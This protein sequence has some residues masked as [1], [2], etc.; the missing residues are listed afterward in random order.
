MLRHSLR[1]ACSRELFALG[2]FI[3]TVLSLSLVPLNAKLRIIV[4][5]DF[6]FAQIA[7]S[8]W[9]GFVVTN[10]RAMQKGGS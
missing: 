6:D 10:M 3:Q 4:L 2:A 8:G 9:T 5:I 1:A 7:I